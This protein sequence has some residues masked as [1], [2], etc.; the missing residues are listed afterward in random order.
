MFEFTQRYADKNVHY[1]LT[2]KFTPFH[3][4]LTKE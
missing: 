4:L 2:G 1:F 3:K